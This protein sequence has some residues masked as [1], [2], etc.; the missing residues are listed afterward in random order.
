[1]PAAD[2]SDALRSH[3]RHER[4]AIAVALAESLHHSA[5]R[6]ETARTGGWERGEVHGEF[7]AD[8][9]PQEPG[10]QHFKLDDE[11]SVLELGGTRPDRLTDVRP[12]LGDEA[13]HGGRLRA[14]AR[15]SA[16]NFLLCLLPAGRGREA[17]GHARGRIHGGDDD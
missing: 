6:Q 2:E 15:Q 13:A 11:D 12:Q 4:M 14:R 17:P 1:M 10:T 16:Q 8:P 5:Q 3:L 7:P 9:T